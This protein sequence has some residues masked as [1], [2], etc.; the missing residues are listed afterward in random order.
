M[1]LGSWALAIAGPVLVLLLVGWIAARVG[2]QGGGEPASFAPSSSLQ[3]AQIVLLGNSVGAAALDP[4]AFSLPTA[5]LTEVG[6][7]PA[8]WL[9]VLRHR[10]FRAGHHPT[11]VVLYAPLHTLTHGPLSDPKGQERLLSLLT[12]PD[13]DLL[14][15]A[16]V[17]GRPP[18]IERLLRGRLR[19]RTQLLRWVSVAPVRIFSDPAT[20]EQALAAQTPVA[21]QASDRPTVVPGDQSRGSV[22]HQEPNPVDFEHSFL[23]LLAREAADNGARFWVVVPAV[24]PSE[25]PT[26]ACT[27][28]TV[29]RALLAGLE[30]TGALV[31]DL[32]WAPMADRDFRSLYHPVESGRTQLTAWVDEAISHGPPVIPVGCAP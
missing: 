31:I 11:E 23:P 17:G 26:R 4:A 19:I 13:P 9:A 12:G 27:H 1:R 5:S 8:H 28:S 32:T 2:D 6:T 3:G 21:L 7:Q 24:R 22:A 14:N 20:V 30:H 29:D 25:R 10:V 16:L 18:T 15:A